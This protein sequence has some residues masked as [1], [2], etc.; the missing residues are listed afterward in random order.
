MDAPCCSSN[1]IGDGAEGNNCEQE[2]EPFFFSGSLLGEN[3][4]GPVDEACTST[5]AAATL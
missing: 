4:G 1:L 5:A 2:L 3:G